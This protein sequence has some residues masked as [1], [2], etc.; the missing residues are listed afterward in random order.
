MRTKL[1]LLGLCAVV[2]GMMSMSAGAAQ[3]ATF[4][5]LLLN[6]KMEEVAFLKAA[7]TGEKDSEHI[8]LDGEVAGFKIAVTCTKFTLNGVNLEAGGKLTEGGKVVFEGCKVFKEAPLKEEYACTVKTGTS[9]AGTVESGEGKGEL[10]LVGTKLLTK[11]EPKAGPTGSFAA[12]KFEGASC[13]LPELNQV[14]GTLYVKD[15]KGEATVHL[16]KHLIEADA[17]ATALYVGGHS[18][19]QLEMTKVLGSVWILLTGVHKEFLFGAM[20]V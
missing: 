10:V 20:D 2:V 15:C 1:G 3:G 14:H 6:T 12:L 5:W 19:L 11:I 17:E 9:P 13:P 7:L 18:A 8:T 4:S 16:E